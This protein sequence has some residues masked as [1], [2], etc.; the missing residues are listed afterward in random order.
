MKR[1]HQ[2]QVGKVVVID[3]VPSQADLLL[4]H[5]QR[6]LEVAQGSIRVVDN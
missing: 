5:L 1:V 2:G 6:S 3:D 4:D